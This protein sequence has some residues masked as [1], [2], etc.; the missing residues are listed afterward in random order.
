MIA[1]IEFGPWLPEGTDYKNPG[2]EVAKNCIP[3]PSGYQPVFALDGTGASVTG[4]IVGAR[5]FERTDG[6][7]VVCVATVSDLYVIVG[8]AVTASGLSLGL[9]ESDRVVFEQFDG[10]V[11]ATTKGGDTWYLS[12]IDS[13]TVFSAVGGTTPSANAMGRVLD[14]LVVGD[15]NDGSDLPY[16]VQWSPFN[17]PRGAWGSDIATQADFQPLDAQQGP[18]TAISGGTFGL[19]FQKNGVS[20]MTYVGGTRVFQFDLYEKN[21]GCVAPQS[22]ARVGD[23]A[24]FLSFDGFFQTD[25]ASVQSISQG[26]IWSWFLDNVDQAYL[27]DIHAA[28]DWERRSVVWFCVSPGAGARTFD[29]QLWFNWETGNWTYVEQAAEYAVVTTRDTGQTLEEIAVTYP[30][31]DAMPV[32]LDSTAFRSAGRVLAAFSGGELATFTGGA[33]EPMF[34]TGS[35]QPKPGYRT[36]IRSVTPLIANDANNTGVSL[37]TRETMSR[38]FSTSAR[39]P[40]GSLGF[41]PFNVD[42]RYFR[43]TIDIPANETWAD[44][45]GLQVEYADAGKH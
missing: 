16:R 39:V 15:L 20:R 44:A 24:Y 37:G 38:T 7:I 13:D 17:N 4:A 40:V 10:E 22:V 27:E 26:R 18:V 42:G 36:F 34:Q 3:S 30:D 1:E 21:R 11:F 35:Y 19:V 6:T 25:G 28:I 33:L 14:F 8:G 31:L 5:A 32:S 23:V 45:Y 41:A 2:L 12:A 9:S 29:L 43:S